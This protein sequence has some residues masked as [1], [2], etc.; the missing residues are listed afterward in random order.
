MS[1]PAEV[2]VPPRPENL[3]RRRLWTA[4]ACA[5]AVVCGV[6]L[7]RYSPLEHSYYPG[8]FFH[9]ATGWHCPGCGGTRCAYALVHGDLPQA[10]AFNLLVVLSLPY[11]A[12]LAVNALC[13]AVTG[14]PAF[15]RHAPAWWPRLVTVVFV[16]FW[17][18]RNL[19]WEPFTYLAP[20]KI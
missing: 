17:V 20:H 15:R 19:P 2:Y 14:R 13:H 18:V 9:W 5:V 11:L 16:L 10:A 7:Y 3:T 12:M 8:C 4:A 6:V 1:S